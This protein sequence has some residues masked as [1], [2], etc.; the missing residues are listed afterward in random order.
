[1]RHARW[2]ILVGFAAAVGCSSSPSGGS[3]GSA[4]SGGTGGIGGTSG[5]G[6]TGGTSGAGGADSGS[7]IT[8]IP[9]E[10]RD[11]EQ[12]GEALVGASF[13]DFPDRKP[14]W[15]RVT[16]LIASLKTRWT[17]AK[18]NVPGLSSSPTAQIEGAIVAL[19]AAAPAQNQKAT[20]DAALQIVAA[21]SDLIDM[22]H[23]SV[24]KQVMHMDA[25][26]MQVAA[27]AHF[28]GWAAAA[29]AR[30]GLGMDW[31]AVKASVGSRVATCQRVAGVATVERDLDAALSNIDTGIAAQD[32]PATEQ[33]AENVLSLVDTLE[34]LF[35]C[36]MG[37]DPPA[38]G[39]GSRCTQTAECDVNQV[40]DPANNGGHCAPDPARA[41]IGTACL[42]TSDCGTDRR[43]VCGTE[44]G[45]N[46]PGGYCTM[47]PCDDIQVCPP[48]ATCVSLGSETPACFHACQADA[49]CR[50]TQG[51]VCQRFVITPPE[52]FGP[53]EYACALPCTRDTDCKMPLTCDVPAGKCKM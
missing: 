36:P 35:N 32:A 25:V 9:S 13:G 33:A 10:V 47:E 18:T 30:T 14:D 6:G 23:P 49:D 19:D 40:C 12:V 46:F 22:F 16:T 44:A 17:K 3:A 34:L 24:P 1:M 11:I 45:D 53:G 28:A 52:G 31:T 51:Y 43:S 39:L 29:T 41:S 37:N 21:V 42:S 7:S 20:I 50:T 5:A 15:A 48:G 4:G 2:W 26:G 27:E 38:H 8:T